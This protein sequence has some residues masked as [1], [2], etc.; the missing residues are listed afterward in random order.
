MSVRL[1]IRPL[2]THNSSTP[3]L[4]GT[5]IHRHTLIKLK[6]YSEGPFAG[7]LTSTLHMTVSV[8]RR[9]TLIGGPWTKGG[10]M[11]D[12]ACY[13]RLCMTVLPFS[14]QHISNSQVEWLVTTTTPTYTTPAFHQIHTSVNFYKYF[15]LPLAVVQWNKLP[16][17]VVMLHALWQSGLLITSYPR[18]NRL[19]FN[20][21][22]NLICF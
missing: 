5:P 6:W 22:L 16:A 10:L 18:N 13:I 12:S 8:K 14:F 19:V 17:E 21:F 20:M 11:L 2:Y 3:P 1:H 9:R 7:P 4:R 15:F